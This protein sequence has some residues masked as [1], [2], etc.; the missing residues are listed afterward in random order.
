MRSSCRLKILFIP[1][2]DVTTASDIIP[3]AELSQQISTAGMEASGTGNMKLALNGAL[4]I[5]TMDGANV[6]MR[7]H[8]G[9]ENIF[10]FGHT[11][12]DLRRL[13]AR[14]YNP[15]RHYQSNKRLKRVIDM[16]ANGYFSPEEPHRYRPI[17][18]SLLGS[19]HFKILADFQSYMDMS[20]RVDS[21]YQ[22][23]EI[24]NQMAIL[25]TARMGFFSSDRTISEY[26]EKVWQ[27]SPVPRQ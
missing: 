8:V 11:A 17:T 27:V 16:I 24:W 5:G 14:R 20:D 7:E 9:A 1:N 22:L 21:I 2:Y 4:T 26:A 3:A 15:R 25:N 13:D 23:P 19:D 10:I 6:E 12:E 18:D